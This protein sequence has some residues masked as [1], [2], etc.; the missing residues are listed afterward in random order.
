MKADSHDP[1]KYIPEHVR[2]QARAE[3]R[4][5]LRTALL[6]ERSGARVTLELPARRLPQKKT[7]LQRRRAKLYAAGLT[8]KGTP[9]QRMLH[10]ELKHLSKRERDC[11]HAKNIYRRKRAKLL[12]AG[13]TMRGTI[14][15]KKLHA[16]LHGLP[17]NVYQRR[18]RQKTSFAPAP[19]EAA[20]RDFRASLNVQVPQFLSAIEREEAA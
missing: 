4:A 3:A 11:V 6:L 2:L 18:W 16:E 5:G 19:R 14:P 13:L 12:A 8:A 17:R 20:Y 7:W 15:Q 9:R 10:P 1:L